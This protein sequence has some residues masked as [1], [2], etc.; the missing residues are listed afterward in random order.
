MLAKVSQTLLALLAGC[1]DQRGMTEEELWTTSRLAPPGFSAGLDD[2]EE[3][4]LVETYR[5]D[6]HLY[7]RVTTKG[8]KAYDAL[9][10]R[11]Q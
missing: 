9:Q 1:Q 7:Y 2:L 4:H 6:G 11:Q 3:R 5:T 10:A 8:R